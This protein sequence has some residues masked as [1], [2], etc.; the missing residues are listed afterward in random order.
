[1]PGFA[2]RNG[3]DRRE[4]LMEAERT[5]QRLSVKWR[6][7]KKI[8]S[9]RAKTTQVPASAIKSKP[10]RPRVQ[11]PKSPKTVSPKL[12]STTR[13]PK[14][15]PLLTPPDSG[16]SKALNDFDRLKET[17]KGL[18]KDRQVIKD[19]Q[20]VKDE[21]VL[22]NAP[23][24]TEKSSPRPNKRKRAADTDAT[25]VAG[26][27]KSTPVSHSSPDEA[28][29]EDAPVKKRKKQREPFDF[30]KGS[31]SQCLGTAIKL[32]LESRVPDDAHQIQYGPFDDGRAF[33]VEDG[34]GST[35]H[36]EEM[37]WAH[38]T[39]KIEKKPGG[40]DETWTPEACYKTM[41]YRFFLAVAMLTEQNVRAE[42]QAAAKGPNVKPHFIN[43]NITFA[44]LSGS[45]D[46]G[47][48][49]KMFNLF[50]ENFGWFPEMIITDTATNKKTVNS[51]FKNMFSETI[52]SDLL[53]QLHEFEP[54]VN[55]YS[56]KW[57]VLPRQN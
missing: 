1:M 39:F 34:I 38:E 44:Q 36:D 13:A 41:K 37:A 46:V 50:T 15:H 12:K 3:Y 9:A 16:K 27:S 35:Y 7:V 55:H 32:F 14:A 47:R 6:H 11:K 33:C 49:T 43:F 31:P 19:Q 53:D 48:S 24:L 23:L 26:S 42:Q 56:H 52:R 17:I 2:E 30:A 57:V 28:D 40:T 22:T 54:T 20:V 45:R 21:Q 18:V 4:A 25:A 51:A 29:C 5:F 8:N 10:R